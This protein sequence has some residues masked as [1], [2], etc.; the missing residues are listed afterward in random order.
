LSD[1]HRKTGVKNKETAG[2]TAK[3]TD[4]IQAQLARFRKIMK[5][6][7]D[8]ERAVFEKAYL[9]TPYKCFGTSLPFT[10]RVAKEFRKQNEEASRE[11]IV[12]LARKLFA[13]EYH[14][15]KRLGL[16]LLQFYPRYLD[17]SVMPLLEE[18]LLQSPTWDLVDDISIHLVGTVLEEDRKAYRYLK[19]WSRS[20]NFWMRRASLI[21]PIL[22]FRKG[23]GDPQLFYTFAERMLE[24]K[25]FFIRKAMG[26]G[27]RE[28]AKADPD[29]AF[30]FLMRI[31]GRVSG[32]T[33]RE[34]AKRLPEE[35]KKQVLRKKM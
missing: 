22:L 33:L 13:S 12:T 23:R 2:D 1:I 14:D 11:Y 9:K 29:E 17:L 4:A 34:G 8:K 30:G 18:M 20:G 27:L 21:S 3:K 26:W 35:L 15:E 25:E 19:K 16:R 32:L 24:E 10:D 7:G 31:K 5:A 28:I 6:G